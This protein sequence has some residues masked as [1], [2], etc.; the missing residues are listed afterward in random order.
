MNRKIIPQD[1]EVAFE[2]DE[3]FFSTTDLKGIIFSGNDIFARTSKYSIEEMIG[4]PHNIVRH[5]DM[6]K[7]IF[8][9]LWEYIQSNRPIVAY[10]KNM[11]KDGSYYWVMALVSPIYD[12]NG[13]K[14]RYISI[15]IKPESK[16]FD[17]AKNLY[18]ELLKAEHI[19]GVEES[20]KLLQERLKQLGFENYD[21]FMRTALKEELKI[22]GDIL[23][24]TIVKSE[25]DEEFLELFNIYEI[26]K[27]IERTYTTIYQFLNTFSYISDTL[28]ERAKDILT[29][30]GDVRL[31]SLNSS[32]ESYK[33]GAQGNSFFVLST[34][35]RKTAEKSGKLTKDMERIL[36]DT[37][38]SIEDMVFYM[39]AS[40]LGIYMM[41][42]FLAE[43]LSEKNESL[44]RINSLFTDITD[45]F[46]FVNYYLHKLYEISK[47]LNKSLTQ[48]LNILGNISLL[49]KRLH[50]LYLTGMV[51]SA[52]QVKTS[53]SLI[54]TQ[55]NNLVEST[56]EAINSLNI[57]LKKILET[58]KNLEEELNIIMEKT[59]EI[60]RYITDVAVS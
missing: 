3:M 12:K 46:R 38:K 55:V 43:I 36:N 57:E 13:E 11:A 19:D 59:D 21:Q 20:Y 22:K 5:P 14:Y 7:V 37:V 1:V 10:V 47:A 16:Y 26:F 31:I 27:D 40:K 25:I 35:M 51:E 18:K 2:K 23:E 50:F 54:F 33:L 32:V 45:N 30:S 24:K 49:I 4:K 60:D 6:P 39:N 42:N 44:L 29:I 28:K 15:R 8:R 17:I 53:F 48:I 56:K 52:H 41:S 34:E 58:N 9:L